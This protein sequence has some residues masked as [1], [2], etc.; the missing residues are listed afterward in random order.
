MEESQMVPQMSVGQWII[1]FLI[2]S[3][4]FVNIVMMFVWA[5]GAMNERKNFAKAYLIVMAVMF[6]VA[7]IFAIIIFTIGA[8]FGTFISS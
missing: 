3:I 4:P 6:V 2:L 1:T 8:S 7:I 5:F